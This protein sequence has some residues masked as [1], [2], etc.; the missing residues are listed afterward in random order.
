MQQAISE[1]EDSLE[2]DTEP[3]LNSNNPVTSN[4]IKIALNNIDSDIST[5][6]ETVTALSA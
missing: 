4:G 1:K 3:T 2:F 6:E 5:L